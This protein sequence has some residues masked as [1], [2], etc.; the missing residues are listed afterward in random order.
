MLKTFAKKALSTSSVRASSQL[1]YDGQVA[2]ISG[3]GAGLGKEYALQFASRGA[4]VVVNDLGGARDGDGASN[5]AADAVVD[6]IK[7]NGGKAVANYNSVTDGDELVKTA[8]DSFGKVDIVVN[9]AGILRDRSLLRISEDDW[10]TILDVHLTG[11]F[12]TSQAAFEHMKTNKFGR[13]IFTSS[14]AGIYGNFGQAN[15]SAAKLGLYGFSNTIA[16]EGAK[17]NITSN[18][19]APLAASRLTEDILP[20]DI[21]DMLKPEYVAPLVLYLCHQDTSKTGGL[22]EVGGGW[23][24]ELRRE[25]AKGAVY[26]KKGEEITVEGVQANFDGIT[27]FDEPTYPT[28]SMESTMEMVDAIVSAE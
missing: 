17:Y 24:G 27:N 3:A 25:R 23:A 5:S 4:S 8:V 14:A 26:A 2:I 16:I 20:P 28:S 7:S 1:R 6:L 15:Y 22:F 11:A 18:T 9:N 13:F 10:N 21:L 12:K 19:I